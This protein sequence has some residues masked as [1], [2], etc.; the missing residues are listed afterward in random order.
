MKP[1][2]ARCVE[3]ILEYGQQNPAFLKGILESYVGNLVNQ[4]VER[5]LALLTPKEEFG[6]LTQI[7]QDKRRKAYEIPRLGSS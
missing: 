3:L 2:R 1:N 7:C 6:S 4:D 5:F